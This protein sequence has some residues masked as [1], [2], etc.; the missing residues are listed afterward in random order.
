MVAVC[1]LDFW[2]ELSSCPCGNHPALKLVMAVTE[3]S[4]WSMGSRSLREFGSHELLQTF[5][6]AALVSQSCTASPTQ[7]KPFQVGLDWSVDISSDFFK[8]FLFLSENI[9]YYE[10]QMLKYSASRSQ[11]RGFP[12]RLNARPRRAASVCGG[13]LAGCV[14]P[15]RTAGKLQVSPRNKV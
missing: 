9:N 15:T 6:L 13:V 8:V 14:L 2:W 3:P 1:L 4:L 10:K 12:N 7:P 5:S 11:A